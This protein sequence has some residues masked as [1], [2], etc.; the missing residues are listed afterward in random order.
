MFRKFK[1]IFSTIGRRGRLP[2]KPR[3]PHKSPPSP[4]ISLITSLVRA[5]VDTTP[6]ITNLDYQSYFDGPDISLSE[7]EQVQQ[8]YS[9]LTTSIDVIKHMAQKIPGFTNLNNEDQE[10]LFQSAALE[11]F[12][13]R[14]AYRMQ[15]NDIKMI[16][17]NGM[18]LQKSQ[19]EKSFG[20]WLPAILE[21]SK[22]LNEMQIDISAF[23]CL[24][25]LVLITGK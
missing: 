20:D 3:S 17:C 14:L 22:N 5:Y 10:L 6:D 13:L 21:F 16:F 1:I 9:I 24:C 4:P 7:A 18:V 12:V 23:S 25:A 11:L 15:E 19:C 8:F 2:S